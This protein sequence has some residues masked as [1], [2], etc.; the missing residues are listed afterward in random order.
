MSGVFSYSKLHLNLKDVPL[1]ILIA[2]IHFFAFQLLVYALR[3]EDLVKLSPLEYTTAVWSIIFGYILW[4]Y[5]PGIK[6]LSGG[7]LIIIGSIIAKRNELKVYFK[8]K[9]KNLYLRKNPASI[10]KDV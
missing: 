3:K 2:V 1:F 8:N 10:D 5:I 6:E 9:Y 4:R 7:V